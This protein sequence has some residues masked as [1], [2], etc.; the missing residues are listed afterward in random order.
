[1]EIVWASLWVSKLVA[2]ALPFVFEMLM[3]VVS[4]G[5]KKYSQVIR[6][7]EFSLSLVGW[8]IASSASF[9]PVSTLKGVRI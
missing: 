5:V 3:G 9:L 7:V 8:A 2:K 1:M 4:S 6:S